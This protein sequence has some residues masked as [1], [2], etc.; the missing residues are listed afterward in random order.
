MDRSPFRMCSCQ[1]SQTVVDNVH[2]VPHERNVV[3]RKT[4]KYRPPQCHI[5]IRVFCMEVGRSNVHLSHRVSAILYYHHGLVKR[6]PEQSNLAPVLN[7]GTYSERFNTSESRSESDAQESGIII[8]S[9]RTPVDPT[10]RPQW[11][12][13]TRSQSS[14]PTK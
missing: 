4:T 10:G 6:V 2:G 3:F 7:K 11:R 12:S 1:T 9:K 14:P 8:D 13:E 5:Y